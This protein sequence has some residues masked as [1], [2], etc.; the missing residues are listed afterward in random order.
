MAGVFAIVIHSF[1][2]FNL[3]VPANAVLFT[4]IAAIA[5]GREPGD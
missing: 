4:V 5:S 3:F 2:D 1:Y